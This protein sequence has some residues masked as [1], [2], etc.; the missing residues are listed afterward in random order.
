M[1]EGTPVFDVSNEAQVFK[2]PGEPGDIAGAVSF[3]ASD[4]ASFI[5]G[6][7]IIVDGGP[8]APVSA[9]GDPG[10]MTVGGGTD[11]VMEATLDAIWR[12]ESPRLVARLTRLVGDLDSAEDVAQDAFVIAI[13]R[14]THD[15]VP[16]SPGGW[17]FNTAVS[18]VS[19]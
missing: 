19:T 12:I 6:Q 15:G 16:D 5:T 11:P 13:G 14:W 7:T 10:P 2:R 9:A 1:F 3:L 17:Q 8:R 18:A 4:D